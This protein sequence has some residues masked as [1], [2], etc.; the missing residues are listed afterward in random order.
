MRK[1]WSINAI[2]LCCFVVGFC[3]EMT[4][5]IIQVS[6]T[7][8][9][10]WKYSGE[11]VLLLGGSVED[12]LFQIDNLVE[13]LDLLKSVGGNYVRNTMSSR[14]VGNLWPFAKND[15]E[16]YDLNE[17]NEAYWTRFSEFLEETGRR[18][19]FVQIEIWATFD[20][21]RDYWEKN[22]FNPKNNINYDERRS[23][24]A[25]VVDSHP[26]YTENNFFRSVPSQMNLALPLWYQKRFV[27][28][29]LSYTLNYGHVL[30]CMDNETSVTSD[31]GKFWALYIQKKAKLA[32]KSVFTTEMWDPHDLDHPMHFETFDNPGIFNFVDISQN[33]H[34]GGENHWKNGLKQIE[35]LES[36][37]YLRPVNNVKIYGND[38]GPHQTTRNAIE[39]FCR[40]VLFGAASARFHRPDTGQGLNEIAQAVIKSIRMV[41]EQTDFFNGRPMNP[42]LFDRAENEAYCRAVAGKEYIVYFTDGGEVKLNVEATGG[43][44][45][46]RW[47]SVLDSEWTE[48]KSVSG[49]DRLTLSCPGTG[50]YIAVVKVADR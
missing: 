9:Q 26:V 21:Y 17:W 25:T 29:I 37:G 16:V 7:H 42:L 31:W 48:T 43:Q 14:D 10:Y 34:Q 23:K 35:Y 46:I 47:L 2:I 20:F 6:D 4:D 15:K 32:G 24:L 30:Y 40:N 27:D 5:G 36:M 18:E 33:N 1:L 39:S 44:F 45:E 3:G 38:G 49:I 13:H 50:H 28:K 19:I 8:P 12:N 22:P 41:V 11:N